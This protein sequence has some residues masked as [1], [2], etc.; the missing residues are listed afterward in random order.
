MY[1]YIEMDSGRIKDIIDRIEKAK[2]ELY[3]CYSELNRY[4]GAMKI[5]ISPDE[6]K[7][8]LQIK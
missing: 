2:E 3:D 6:N 7:G 8:D 5:K 1:A 4:P